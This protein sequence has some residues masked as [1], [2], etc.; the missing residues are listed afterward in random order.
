MMKRLRP[1]VSIFL[2]PGPNY[3][4]IDRQIAAL[5]RFHSDVAVMSPAITQGKLRTSICAT[6]QPQNGEGA[7]RFSLTSAAEAFANLRSAIG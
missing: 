7:K 4:S 1:V 6:R 2:D 5:A 3:P